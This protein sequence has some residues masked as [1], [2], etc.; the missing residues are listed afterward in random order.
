MTPEQVVAEIGEVD[1]AP[2][3]ANVTKQVLHVR[4]LLAEH[5]VR[6]EGYVVEAVRNTQPSAENAP[7][8]ESF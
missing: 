7:P 3:V 5:V 8:A 2:I 1:P 6:L 4:K